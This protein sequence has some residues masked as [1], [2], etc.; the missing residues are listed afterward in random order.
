MI[1]REI[2]VVADS[3]EEARHKAKE[4]VAEDMFLVASDVL[5][6]GL[7]TKTFTATGE[8]SAAAMNAAEAMLPPDVVVV[9]KRELV[10]PQVR[11]ITID[12]ADEPTARLMAKS[13]LRNSEAIVNL[14]LATEGT[15]GFM[16]MGK[17]INRY[18][19][20]IA[21]EAMAEIIVREKVLM[22]IVVG[23]RD[24]L[25]LTAVERGDAAE[26]HELLAEGANPD[27]VDASGR[28]VLAVAA[29]LGREQ[30]LVELLE[31][32]A[33]AEGEG[34]QRALL[35]AAAGHSELVRILLHAGADANCSNADGDMPLHLAALGGHTDIVN[36]LL[37]KRAAVNVQDKK[38]SWT[39]LHKAAWNGHVDIVTLLLDHNADMDL[40][41]DTGETPLHMAILNGHTELAKL[42]IAKGADLHLRIFAGDYTGYSASHLA[43]QG[44]RMEIAE[45]IVKRA[46]SLNTKT[47]RTRSTPLHLAVANNLID[48][49]TLLLDGGADVNAK[50]YTADTPLH[51]AASKG[52]VE[53]VHKLIAA[54]ANVN[55]I[56]DHGKTPLVYA[57]QHGFSGLDQILIKAGAKHW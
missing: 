31:A 45:A 42:L 20:D 55:A 57:T 26:V 3:M 29:E 9:D 18:E 52:Y 48:M 34:G 40:S 5:R 1:Q 19:L 43:A 23:D 38:G 11:T 8:T 10:A 2:K 25:L 14:R 30:L 15:K 33:S 39:P 27:A 17:S 44:N 56:D 16:G 37:D 7:E 21:Q 28:T 50:D 53:L 36:M 47:D 54:G 24:F 49:A 51:L 32:G 13:Q 46:V 41:L 4:A 35:K 22:S 12:A 6:D